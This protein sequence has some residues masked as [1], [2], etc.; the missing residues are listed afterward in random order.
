MAQDW[1]AR[2]ACA[3]AD[4]GLFFPKNER[5]GSYPA[6]RICLGCPVVINCGAFACSTGQ[7][8]VWGAMTSEQRDEI[9]QVTPRALMVAVLWSA[10]EVA[11]KLP[12]AE[13]HAES[14]CPRCGA[15]VRAG[16]LPK[17]RTGPGSVCGKPAT[18]NKGCRCDP[19]VLAKSA[20]QAE[21]KRRKRDA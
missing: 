10:A 13:E 20:Y 12:P 8:G 21:M 14:E 19:C 1:K 17:D 7:R 2:A 6:K 16:T 11:G 4:P 5:T 9:E 15:R 18:Y 3:N